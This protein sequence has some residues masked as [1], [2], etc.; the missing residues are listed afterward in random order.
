ML[1]N[2]LW[3][4]AEL[5][6]GEWFNGNLIACYSWN[7]T[8]TDTSWESSCLSLVV[9]QI[10]GKSIT[11]S[12]LSNFLLIRFLA[13]DPMYITYNNYMSPRGVLALVYYD[14]H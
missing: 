5:C 12:N 11:D 13:T 7:Y 9:N 4:T 10:I 8:E 14:V 1:P 6:S 2:K 3:L